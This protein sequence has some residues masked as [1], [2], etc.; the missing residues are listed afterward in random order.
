MPTALIILAAGLGRRMDSEL[1]KVLHRLAG[2]P[3]LWHA[4][5]AGGTLDPE[6]TVVVAGH[7]A[8]TVRRSALEFDNRTEVVVQTEQLGTGHAVAQAFSVLK[9]FKGRVVV[10]FGDTPFVRAETLEALEASSADVTVLGFEPA[11]VGRYGRLLMA[12]DKLERIVEYRDATE[13]ERAIGLCNSGV[14]AADADLL[15]DLVQDEDLSRY[16]L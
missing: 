6:R 10:L 15:G 11:D 3:L 5:A 13:A 4:M 8:Q 2:A 7:D 9:G 14:V 12:G 16:S 1:P